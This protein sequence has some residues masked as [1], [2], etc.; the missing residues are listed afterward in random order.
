[1]DEKSFMPNTKR[2]TRN[3][4]SAS[5]V[6]QHRCLAAAVVFFCMMTCIGALPGTTSAPSPLVFDKLLH[7][8]AYAVLSTLLYAGLAGTPASRALRTLGLAFLFGSFNEAIRI[9]L[10]YHS[11][12]WLD[13]KFDML[14]ALTCVGILM[15]LHPVVGARVA[16][17]V[18]AASSPRGP[19]APQSR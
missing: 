16:Q 18:P 6:M 4:S 3:D 19:G 7:F 13:W 9:L 8:A 14:A 17:A 12:N 1:M 2:P 5:Q 11:P 15:L 10:P